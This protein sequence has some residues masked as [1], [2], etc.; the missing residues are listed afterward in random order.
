M[1]KSMVLEEANGCECP[2]AGSLARYPVM[3]VETLWSFDAFDAGLFPSSAI[4]AL[5]RS[6]LK[7]APLRSVARHVVQGE[8]PVPVRVTQTPLLAF[9]PEK[10]GP[11]VVLARVPL[12]GVQLGRRLVAQHGADDL[13]IRY[14]KFVIANSTPIPARLPSFPNLNHATSSVADVTRLV[15]EANELLL[16]PRLISVFVGAPGAL[17]AQQI[18]VGEVEK[19][20]EADE[21]GGWEHDEEP[22]YLPTFGFRNEGAVDLGGRQNIGIVGV[23][24]RERCLILGLDRAFWLQGGLPAGYGE[25]QVLRTARAPAR[26]VDRARVARVSYLVTIDAVDEKVG[27]GRWLGWVLEFVR[28]T[29]VV[30]DRAADDFGI[31]ILVFAKR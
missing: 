15:D 30:K 7:D 22:T 8:V 4:L 6:T 14:A 29:R 21:E 20:L 12:L 24:E 23:G 19:V 13:G 9:R 25:L 16:F 26:I 18:R 31:Q 3:P 28:D 2:T 27:I 5:P 10:E 1:L 17:L 11:F